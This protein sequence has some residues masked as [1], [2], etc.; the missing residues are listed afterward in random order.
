[1]QGGGRV[2]ERNVVRRRIEERDESRRRVEERK[3]RREEMKWDEM[4]N[5]M[6]AGYQEWSGVEIWKRR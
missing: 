4:E 2:E 1:M 6:R 3:G 5:E